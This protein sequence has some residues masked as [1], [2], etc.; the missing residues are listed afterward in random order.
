MIK[1][2]GYRIYPKLFNDNTLRLNLTSAYESPI[3]I[4]WLYDGE[5]EL[6]QVYYITRHFQ[7]LYPSSS[8][9]FILPYI[10]NARQDRVQEQT[11]V[12]TLKYFCEIINSLHFDKVLVFDPHSYVSQ[13]L[14]N[15]IQIGGPEKLIK[16]IFEK[17]DNL[18]PFFPD[19]GGMKRG[20]KY[21]DT[22]YAF[23]IKERN[24]ET[25]M[26]ENLRIA[27]ATHII[28]G[29]DILIIDDICSRGSTVYHAAKTLKDY[30]ANKIY[31]YVSHCENT[32]FTP[33]FQGKSLLTIPNLIEKVYTTNSILRLGP[34]TL[35]GQEKIELIHE[36]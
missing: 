33:H 5:E 21:V 9:T 7:E 31:L 15:N 26:I 16:Q 36:F 23:G 11:E 6:A 17:H 22:P 28:S 2:N 19:E 13:A 10:P 30:G 3:Q 29:K 34:E 35:D 8:I 32:V 24:Y 14:I 12:F 25:G 18:L 20:R 27:G 4:A 1:I